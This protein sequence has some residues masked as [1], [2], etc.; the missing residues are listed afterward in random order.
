MSDKN[1]EVVRRVLEAF[2]AGVNSG[3]FAAAW[4]T[5]YLAADAQWVAFPELD[6]ATYR[7]RAG[8]VEFMR[9]WSEDFERLSFRIERLIPAGDDRVVAL[10]H[11]SAVGRR[12]SSV[13]GEQEYANVYELEEGRVVRVHAYL[14]LAQAL[15]RTDAGRDRF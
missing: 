10:L 9:T 4:D 2:V 1:V 7:G 3:D 14:E 8:F 6:Q 13:P 12:G 15:D 11:Q 5:G